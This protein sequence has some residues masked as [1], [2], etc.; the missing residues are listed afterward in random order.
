MVSN[1]EIKRMLEARRKGIDIKKEKANTA[2]YKICPNCKTKNPE[3]ALFCV[4]CGNK[5]DKDVKVECPSCGTPNQSDA[6]FCVECGETLKKETSTAET[7]QKETSKTAEAELETPKTG[8]TS[9]TD[10]PQ[11]TVSRTGIPSSVPEHGII[12]RTNTKKTCPSCK[13]ENPKSSKFCV[14][15]GEK[16][17]DSEKTGES[18]EKAA[19]I[20]EEPVL[21]V[22]N[23]P[24]IEKTVVEE[25]KASKTSLLNKVPDKNELVPED[26]SEVKPPEI[27]VHENFKNM[28]KEDLKSEETV[29]SELPGKTFKENEEVDPVDK[30]KKAKELMDIGAITTEEFEIIKKKYLEK[31]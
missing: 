6:K 17:D 10:V 8:E 4:K 1:E 26:S 5:M 9:E 12:S 28:K 3:K 15:C 30:I 21:E 14:V 7:V 19:A 29:K 2:N 22:P 13:S 27:K 31:I 23:E 24:L 16:F 11:K 18:G 20:T 25:V